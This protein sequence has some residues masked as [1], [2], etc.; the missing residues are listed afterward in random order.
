[1]CILVEEALREWPVPATLVRRIDRVRLY[2]PSHRYLE[3]RRD[4][5]AFF[6][7]DTVRLL[8]CLTSEAERAGA[9]VRFAA[10][11]GG[12]AM[13]APGPRLNG[14]DVTCRFLVGADGVHSQVARCAGLDRNK[15]LLKGVLRQHDPSALASP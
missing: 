8:R 9:E 3:L 14:F 5:Y 1:M 2:A 6:A 12:Y 4:G 13:D 7:T 10:P 11:F 15:R